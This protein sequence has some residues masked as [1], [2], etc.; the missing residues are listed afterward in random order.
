MNMGIV[1]NESCVCAVVVEAPQSAT[2]EA[3][4]I[5]PPTADSSSSSAAVATRERSSFPHLPTAAL[6]EDG[7]L[8]LMG[9]LLRESGKI[10]GQ[11]AHLVFATVESLKDRVELSR[12]VCFLQEC[13][14]LQHRKGAE[15]NYVADLEGAKSIYDIFKVIR[16]FYSFFGYNLME[17]IIATFGT[18]DDKRRLAEYEPLFTEFCKRRVY[19]CPIDAFGR[20]SKDDFLLVVKLKDELEKYTLQAVSAFRSKL[21]EVFGLPDGVLQFIGAEEGCVELHFAAASSLESVIFPLSVRQRE[22]L[23]GEGVLEL[24]GGGHHCSLEEGGESEQGASM[25]HCS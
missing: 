6:S 18:D 15:S 11:F 17:E 1:S 3:K 13:P 16:T 12:L 19:E 21:C 8:S 9:R 23:R 22:R 7:R 2:S 24:R 25:Q 14:L 5:P 20:K 10:Q 4:V